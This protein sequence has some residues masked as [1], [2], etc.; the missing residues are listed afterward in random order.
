L[1]RIVEARMQL[2]A[3][4]EKEVSRTPALSDREP[5]GSGPSNRHGMPKLPQR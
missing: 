3:R 5:M 2:K 4:F 1:E